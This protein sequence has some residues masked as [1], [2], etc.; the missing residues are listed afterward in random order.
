MRFIF[1]FGDP[2]KLE[3]ILPTGQSGNFM[4]KHYDDMTQMWLKGKYI[5]LPITEEKFRTTAVDEM[6]L[7]P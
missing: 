4:S 5:N 7:N 3:F 6:I 2:D 1:D